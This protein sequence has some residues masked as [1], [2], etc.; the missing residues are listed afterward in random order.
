MEDGQISFHDVVYCLYWQ[1]FC[2]N[3]LLRTFL[4]SR[5]QVCYSFK[6]FLI[7]D[8]FNEKMT[9]RCV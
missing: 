1:N 4:F 7:Y 6:N 5:K 2:Y 9:L 3:P 8:N